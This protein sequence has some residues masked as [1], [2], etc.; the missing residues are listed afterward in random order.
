MPYIQD[1]I[2]GRR[3]RPLV[4]LFLWPL[5]YAGQIRLFGVKSKQADW[6]IAGCIYILGLLMS[7]EYT[8]TLGAQQLFRRLAGNRFGVPLASS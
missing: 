1:M 8:N 4:Y 7:L 5:N 2:P 6:C 3:I